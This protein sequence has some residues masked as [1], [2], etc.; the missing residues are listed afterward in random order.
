MPRAKYQIYVHLI[1]AT[2]KRE[3]FIT[4]ELESIIQNIIR[5]KC[6]KFDL[7][8]L[9]FGNKEDHIHLLL[10]I[11]PNIKIADFVAEAKGTTSY[12]INHDAGQ[13]LYWQDGYGCFSI[14]RSELKQVKE[15]VLNQQKHH[16]E[17]TIVNE[18]E[19]C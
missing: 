9:A 17:K 18:L 2:K 15:Y 5:E 12:Y 6:R 14:G 7:E 4:S 1:W 19:D 3:P 8:L 13:L 11:N 10:S 16:Y